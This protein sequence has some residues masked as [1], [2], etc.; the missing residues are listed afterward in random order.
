[1]TSIPQKFRDLLL[2]FRRRS[3]AANRCDSGERLEAH[4]ARVVVVLAC[5]AFAG[6][7]T[8]A[9]A[10]VSTGDVVATRAYLR[11][12]EVYVQAEYPGAEARVAAIEAR[13]SEVA[14]ACPSALA[15]APRDTAFEELGEELGT[16]DWYAGVASVRSV[17]LRV[18]DAI[19]HLRWSDRQLTRLV[20]AEAAEERADVGLV[21][22][23]VCGQI[24]AWKASAYTTLPVSVIEFL[25]HVEAIESGSTIGPSEESREALIMHLLRRY[26]DTNERQL[27]ERIERLEA[28]AHKRL[29]AGAT[30]A[31]SKLAEAMGIVE[32]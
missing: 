28:R 23:D 8:G 32:L 22:P 16:S 24:A 14:G 31:G 26:E 12:S 6:L 17:T 21:L 29:V 18:A 9:S 7:D 20:H 3:H 19:G 25:T 4:R 27:A 10:S 1:V 2:R 15:Y 13:G 11:A 5:L 30:T